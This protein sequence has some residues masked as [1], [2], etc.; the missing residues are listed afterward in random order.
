[1]SPNS[2]AQIATQQF[3]DMLVDIEY[4]EFEDDMFGNE[5]NLRY[6]SQSHNVDNMFYGTG[7]DDE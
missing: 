7:D 4:E 5:E 3:Y 2:E 1:M 6:S